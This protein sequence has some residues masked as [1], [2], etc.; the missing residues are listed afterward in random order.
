MAYSTFEQFAAAL[1]EAAGVPLPDLQLDASGM[2][3]FQ[4][5]TRGVGI[6]LAHWTVPANENVFV[7]VDLGTIAPE[8]ELATLRLLA[9][10]NFALLSRS[11]PV[12][13]NAPSG[14]VVL[15]QLISMNDLDAAGALAM[16]KNLAAF[17][18]SWRAD[19][20]FLSVHYPPA[21]ATSPGSRALA[22]EQS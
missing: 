22:K 18:L 19:P 14:E 7:L 15:R 4:L 21:S 8:A 20:T 16:I 10:A 3:A 2:V 17:A 12:F 13:C 6:E 11:A 9:E 1:C 5:T